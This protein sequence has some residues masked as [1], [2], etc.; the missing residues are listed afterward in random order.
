MS[1]LFDWCLRHGAAILFVIALLVLVVTFLSF[2]TGVPGS[3]LLDG[4][5]QE[6]PQP[7]AHVWLIVTAAANALH[8]AALP[9]FGALVIDR[10]DRRR[11]AR[12]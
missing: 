11:E 7:L 5:A 2:V 3:D 10:L 12:A 9:F 1:G 6:K 8:T 4:T